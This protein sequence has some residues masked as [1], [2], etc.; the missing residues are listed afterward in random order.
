M[1]KI[2]R[3]IFSSVSSKETA[4][5]REM[6]GL[7]QK[8][9]VA[10]S[11]GQIILAIFASFSL[12]NGVSTTLPWIFIGA[13]LVTNLFREIMFVY[14]P[15]VAKEKPNLWIQIFSVSTWLTSL[16]WVCLT[17]YAMTNRGAHPHFEFDMLL[18]LAG[19][20]TTAPM[21]LS[22]YRL[23][24]FGFVL[25]CLAPMFIYSVFFHPQGYLI[26]AGVVLSFIP[27]LIFQIEVQT[28]QVW[29]LQSRRDQYR[30]VFDATMESI[31]IHDNG[32]IIE[33]NTAFEKIFGYTKEEIRGRSILD[34]TPLTDRQQVLTAMQSEYDQ[35]I[36]AR[37]VRKSG[38]I[39]PM[40]TRGRFFNFEGK[41]VRVVCALDITERK[42]SEQAKIEQ[43]THEKT[44][45][46]IREK[47]VLESS[48]LK[49]QFLANMSHEIRTPLHAVISISDLLKEMELPSQAHRYIRTLKDSGESLLT[50]VNDILDY[51]K[52]EA[53]RFDLEK[54]DFN[55]V[56][57][58]EAQIELMGEKARQKNLALQ[59]F[60][61]PQLPQTLR[62]DFG[63]LGQILVNLIGN[64]IKFTPAG[65]IKVSCIM[66][67]HR[68]HQVNVRFEVRDTGVGLSEEKRLQLFKPFTQ[69][70]ASTARRYGGTGLGLS[71]CRSL[72]ELM[73]GQIDF[74]SHGSQGTTFW[75]EIPLDVIERSSVGQAA[76]QASPQEKKTESHFPK[77]KVLVAEDNSTN[78]MV[79]TAILKRLEITAHVVNNG[80]EAV[81]AF[82]RD[83]YDLI[84]MD[85]QMPEMDGCT[86]TRK[87]RELEKSEDGEQRLPIVALT[88]NVMQ[89]DRNTCIESGM[90]DFLGKP[91]RRELLGQV[92]ER[93]LA[94]HKAG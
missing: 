93:Y 33:A 39:F 65:E 90:D 32:I 6:N 29:E 84:L 55:I 53:G 2:T 7:L 23:L 85:V 69:A 25:T 47:S 91:V 80:L 37:G 44:L 82:K 46:E 79:I 43:I 8:K 31:A 52:I 35:P 17:I 62:G 20:V 10:S 86:A 67:A 4:I 5:R 49:S 73:K 74:I 78:Q 76:A 50:L 92:L 60:I 18:I 38:E 66:K 94:K 27:Y 13:L 89:D 57:L 3:E 75:F 19:V 11:F 36:E 54:V 81:D 56:N 68:D 77:A 61:D 21:A 59:A 48:R 40:E 22:P 63:R 42:R 83:D 41:I 24:A 28:R 71:I 12:Y 30:A 88:A 1:S 16:F 87:I 70:D 72:V 58:I 45:M 34:L 15:Q 64:A 26:T 14:F 51:S 9:A